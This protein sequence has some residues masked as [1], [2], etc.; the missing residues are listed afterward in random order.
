[1]TS[2]SV[3]VALRIKPIAQEDAN[4]LHSS[5]K[6]SRS[7]V[8]IVSD[9]SIMVDSR[10]QFTFDAVYSGLSSQS[11]VFNRSAKDMADQFLDGF[12]TTILAYGQSGS[13]KTFTTFGPLDD[14]TAG[15]PIDQSLEGIIP[16][17]ARYI[18]SRLASNQQS[19]QYQLT[20]SFL[21]VYNEDLLDLLDQPSAKEKK[22]NPNW[23]NQAT[24]AVT[25]REK[26][27]AI[28]WTGAQEVQITSV[29]ELLDVLKKGLSNRTTFSTNQNEQSSRSHAIFSLSLRQNRWVESPL[30]SASNSATG[31]R[32]GDWHILAS[33]FHFVDLAGSERLKRTGSTGDRQREGIRINS[34]LMALGNVIFALSDERIAHIPYRESKLT[35]LLQ[36]SLGGNSQTLMIAC[37]SPTFSDMAETLNS[38]KYA[39]RARNIK[40]HASVNSEYN[41]EM[42]AMQ[43]E[44]N[45][46]RDELI[47]WQSGEVY[48][49]IEDTLIENDSL[50]IR[51]AQVTDERNEMQQHSDYYANELSLLQSETSYN[52]LVE[53]GTPTEQWDTDSL[54]SS[55]HYSIAESTTTSASSIPVP[56]SRQQKSSRRYTSDVSS[57]KSAEAERIIRK[58]RADLREVTSAAQVYSSQIDVLQT[59]ARDQE[60]KI[61]QQKE[62]AALNEKYIS[63]LEFRLEASTVV[64]EKNT[65]V[66]ADLKEHVQQLTIANQGSEEYIQGLESQLAKQE[67]LSAIV[68]LLEQEI[69]NG[70]KRE[71]D[72]RTSTIDQLSNFKYSFQSRI[73]QIITHNSVSYE[74]RM[75]LTEVLNKLDQ[76]DVIVV[77]AQE[78]E[79][80]EDIVARAQSSESSQ[81][82]TARDGLAQKSESK[83]AQK[84]ESKV[85]W[86]SE[87]AKLLEDVDRLKSK[88]SMYENRVCVST[89]MSTDMLNISELESE[90]EE[91]RAKSGG[92]QEKVTELE[93]VIQTSQVKTSQIE[94]RLVG[95]NHERADL[96]GKLSSFQDQVD[97]LSSDLRERDSQISSLKKT[98][99]LK[100]ESLVELMNSA[101]SPVEVSRSIPTGSPP[102]V[103]ADTLTDEVTFS[104]KGVDPLVFIEYADASV[105]TEAYPTKPE[106]TEVGV[107]VSCLT[108]DAG[109]STD[110]P[111]LVDAETFTMQITTTDSGVDPILNELIDAQVSTDFTSYCDVQTSTSVTETSEASV[112]AMLLR[113]PSMHME[114]NTDVAS[115]AEAETST[116]SVETSEASIEAM[117]IRAPSMHMETNTDVASVAEAETSTASV[118]TSEASI[119]AM[120]IRAPSMHMETN[121]EAIKSVHAETTTVIVETREVALE[122]LAHETSSVGTRTDSS[123][124]AEA[125]TATEVV[126]V[127]AET[128]AVC[129]VTNVETVTTDLIS[130]TE[131]AIATDASSFVTLEREE[132]LLEKVSS[133][134]SVIKTREEEFAVERTALT[135]E[136]RE[137]TKQMNVLESSCRDLKNSNFDLEDLLSKQKA[138]QQATDDL[139]S[140]LAKSI[141]RSKELESYNNDLKEKLV[142]LQAENRSLPQPNENILSLWKKLSANEKIQ[143]EQQSLISR[144]ENQLSDQDYNLGESRRLLEKAEG[145]KEQISILESQVDRLK[146]SL[147]E[148]NKA[149][150]AIEVHGARYAFLKKRIKELE[151]QGEKKNRSVSRSLSGSSDKEDSGER[152]RHLE[153]QIKSSKLKLAEMDSLA[154]KSKDLAARVESLESSLNSSNEDCSLISKERDLAFAQ[155]A[156][157]TTKYETM[158]E[159]LHA[160]I[161]ELRE[162]VSVKLKEVESLKSD[163]QKS[164]AELEGQLAAKDADLESDY[165]ENQR[166]LESKDSEIARI[167]SE[168]SQ[169]SS[170]N[171]NLTH[172]LEVTQADLELALVR[173]TSLSQENDTLLSEQTVVQTNGGQANPSLGE[174]MTTSS[175]YEYETRSSHSASFQERTV[176]TKTT[177]V[178]HSMTEEHSVQ[179]IYFL[180]LYNDTDIV[181]ITDSEKLASELEEQRTLCKNLESKVVILQKESNRLENEKLELTA[182]IVTIQTMHDSV[183]EIYESQLP[184]WETQV[185]ELR[186]TIEDLQNDNQEL[187]ARVLA[188]QAVRESVK[189]MYDD[190]ILV[191]QNLE[192]D[193]EKQRIENRELSERIVSMQTL[194][195]TEL[196]LRDSEARQKLEESES[197][198]SYLFQKLKSTEADLSAVQE[199]KLCHAMQMEELRGAASRVVT[200][201]TTIQHL[202]S[203]LA[204]AESIVSSLRE[205][206]LAQAESASMRSAPLSTLITCSIAGTQTASTEVSEAELRTRIETLQ[207][208]L[209]VAHA[210]GEKYKTA[211]ADLEQR[212]CEMKSYVASLEVQALDHQSKITSSEALL[213]SLQDL[214][215]HESRTDRSVCAGSSWEAQCRECINEKGVISLENE[216]LRLENVMLN[217]QLEALDREKS[218][219]SEQ[220]ILHERS[221]VEYR[222]KV[223]VYESLKT[224]EESSDSTLEMQR[225][226]VLLASKD[227]EIKLLRDLAEELSG[228]VTKLD[229]QMR[230]LSVNSIASISKRTVESTQKR[231]FEASQKR[232]FESPQM[233]D[234]VSIVGMG[235]LR[236]TVSQ[237]LPRMLSGDRPS[238]VVSS[239]TVR[240]SKVDV[241]ES[242]IKVLVEHITAANAEVDEVIAENNVLRERLNILIERK[243]RGG[244]WKKF[245]ESFVEHNEQ[246]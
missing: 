167:S 120:L 174:S 210:S 88:L 240:S 134:T 83:L 229:S 11:Q 220:I 183:K 61:T 161:S 93:K 156:D 166:H 213:A 125:E 165:L 137:V 119:E 50:K 42:A 221:L 99:S 101:Q 168:L 154:L 32:A 194:H 182:R 22:N 31:E 226:R 23:Y 52:A 239:S 34:G 30:K 198:Y 108:M 187:T 41:S 150:E 216:S 128:S 205:K 64:L 169:I 104:E 65:A 105:L 211:V 51:L 245:K 230:R 158:E 24:Q 39:N 185:R 203:E 212:I 70:R 74:I 162:E 144:L 69:L 195:A 45:R 33:K 204:V 38:L 79:D 17:T 233:M 82:G 132:E 112:E 157:A 186:S 138:S 159:S 49:Q 4:D 117:L 153:E 8:D 155:L 78:D 91:N 160:V 43:A 98:I 126:M 71:A 26:D 215:E 40:N 59:R 60:S 197:R 246:K 7:I 130:T 243:K 189:E 181:E 121:T 228:K 47:G 16:Q 209:C 96:F 107:S 172:M 12:N 80:V 171:E 55:S 140:K 102:S 28:S 21:E 37:V 242:K 2:S 114:T 234:E 222:E 123:D 214:G 5:R 180:F 225:L 177:H 217:E 27:G 206:E 103:D 115:V 95:F 227:S 48:Q 176:V 19:E 13:G 141:E 122:S 58:L 152:I 68:T 136:V 84:S 192:V 232:A 116:A 164:N 237:I 57:L 147:A 53:P 106:V 46:L 113:A 56:T 231:T 149:N 87:R 66:V 139:T 199:E 81:N 129:D 100:D 196:S 143:K 54:G 86:E 6:G 1:M 131:S 207:A 201:E 90:I 89:S 151:A 146:G 145:Y 97:V 178:S 36:D 208:E 148:S 193:S 191:L 15:K 244:W 73:E 163:L 9:K 10:K 190:T 235:S 29:D 124:T 218:S 241:L 179:G 110:S 236:H 224:V 127:N 92:L 67:D 20:A 62:R 14:D 223:T 25:I 202:E 94:D 44:I 188:I 72:R 133:L 238:S 175:E 75:E 18:F 173:L 63:Q 219:L 135:S 170:D 77:P 118:E 109:V 111:G 184:E 142:A 85:A 76:I 200:C 35:R 3:K